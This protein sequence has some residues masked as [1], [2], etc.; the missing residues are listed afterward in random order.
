MSDP[1]PEGSVAT[2]TDEERL[3]QL[4][5]KQE[6][7][8]RLSGFSNFAVSFSIISVLAGCLT[9]YLIAMSNGGPAA[10]TLGWLLVGGLVTLVSLSMA[11]VCSV[12]PTAG[13]LYWWAYATAK[14]NKAAWAW[15]TGWFNFLGQVA[16]TGAIDYGAALTTS[17]FFNL[18]FGFTPSKY[19]VFLVFFVIILIHG[20]LNTFGVDLVRLLSDVSAWWHM[21]GVAVI[22]IVLVA[23]PDHHY[24]ISKVFLQTANSTGLHGAGVAIYAFLIGLLMAQYTF[25]GYDASAHLSEETHDAAIAAP[26]GIVSSVVVSLIAGFL[27]LFAVTWAIQDYAGEAASATGFPPAQIFID[28]AGR[29]VGEFLLFICV[30]AQFFCGMASV[31]ANSRMAYAF[32]RDGALPGSRLWSRVNARTGTPTNSIW[33]CVTCS[34][35][36]VLPALKNITAYAAATAIAVIGL[37]VAYVLPV[38]LRLRDKDFQ[39]GPWNLGRWSKPIGW[40]SVVWVVIICIMFMLPTVYP[41]TSLN[42]NYTVVAVVVVLGGATLWWVL[43]AKNWFTGPRPNVAGF[44]GAVPSSVDFGLPTQVVPVD[45]PVD[46]PL[47]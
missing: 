13:G 43:S 42:F 14:K 26:R 27:L 2:L 34:I 39:V 30:L 44:G 4:G 23:V 47:Q 10:I 6:L 32:S 16:V 28:A 41:I 46:E 40:I 5:Y 20:F 25:T 24:P 3:A 18:I 33:L 21:A 8:R 37:Y 45:E 35:V 19:N 36:L 1:I 29:H 31:T 7:H 17:A 38:Y 12:Y 9:S 22:V 15:F 11:E